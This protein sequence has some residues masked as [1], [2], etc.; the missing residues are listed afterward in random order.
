MKAHHPDGLRSRVVTDPGDPQKLTFVRTMSSRDALS[1]GLAEQLTDL[2]TIWEGGRELRFSVVERAW[3][4]PERPSRYPAASIVGLSRGRY[5]SSRM[6]P[7][8]LQTSDGTGR[9]LRVTSEFVQDFELAIW[10]TDEVQRGALLAMVEDAL[11]P[12]DW[13]YGMRLELPYLF[14]LRATYE[15]RDV[16]FSDGGTTAVQGEWRASI[17]IAASV[18]HTVPVGDIPNMRLRTLINVT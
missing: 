13:M 3:S 10:A 11:N 12:V 5:D 16:G 4:A 1:R 7:E 9:A 18:P 8:T 2:S 15:P 6:S 14:G 17:G